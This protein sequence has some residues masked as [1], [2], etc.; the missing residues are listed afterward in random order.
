MKLYEIG[1]KKLI[2]EIISI[3]PM[4]MGVLKEDDVAD[5]KF[6]ELYLALKIDG[7]SAS[8]AKLPWTTWGDLGWKAVTATTSDIIVKGAKPL[9]YL[10]SIGVPKNFNYNDFRTFISGIKEALDYY[11][12]K[13]FGGDLNASEKDVWI[14]IAGLGEFK[15]KPIP[16]SGA[17]PGLMV[18]A[19]GVFGL[20]GMGINAYFNGRNIEMFKNCLNAIKRPKARTNLLDLLIKYRSC[21]YASTDVSDGLAYSLWNI[22]RRSK[23]CIELTNIPIH[24]E[25][26]EY[27]RMYNEDPTKLALYGG[28]EFEAIL[29]VDGECTKDLIHEAEDHGLSISVIGKTSIGHGVYY[30]GKLVESIGWDNIKGY[31]KL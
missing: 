16:M 9:G 3:L 26:L 7:F 8:L 25:V 19:T 21:I 28:E 15:V 31:T 1:E 18:L 20:T 24:D 2:E 11:E 22:A 13:C 6:N 27:A 14:D 23:V 4:S 17:K 30:K 12:V 5:L 29:I 10:I